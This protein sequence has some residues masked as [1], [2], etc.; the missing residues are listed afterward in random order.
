M[1]GCTALELI[2]GTT[3][4]LL[5]TMIFM[6]MN[7]VVNKIRLG[8]QAYGHLEIVIIFSKVFKGFSSYPS[9]IC[10]MCH[11]WAATP[12]TALVQQWEDRPRPWVTST[13]G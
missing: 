5:T 11:V 6:I 10:D 13:C 1:H 8:W 4:T 12:A 3:S 2:S 7:M 9:V